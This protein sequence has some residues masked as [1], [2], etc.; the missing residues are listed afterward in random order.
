MKR[1]Q[2]KRTMNSR[3]PLTKAWVEEAQQVNLKNKKIPMERAMMPL[4]KDQ[5]VTM[6]K[7]KKNP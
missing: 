1:N 4:E 6:I 3:N 7:R 5:Q 2:K